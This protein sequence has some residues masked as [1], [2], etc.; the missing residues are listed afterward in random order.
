MKMVVI[1]QEAPEASR[2]AEPEQQQQQESDAE[3][4]DD[5]GLADEVDSMLETL[6]AKLQ[7]T[8]KLTPG[9][10]FDGGDDEDE[11]GFLADRKKHGQIARGGRGSS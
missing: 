2:A 4:E 8:P 6:R 7:V 5:E 3:S 9:P 1:T 10:A 11:E